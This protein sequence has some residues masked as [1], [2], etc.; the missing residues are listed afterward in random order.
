LLRFRI[1]VL[2]GSRDAVVAFQEREQTGQIG[3]VDA[4]TWERLFALS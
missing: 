2:C 4:E 1:G 3:V